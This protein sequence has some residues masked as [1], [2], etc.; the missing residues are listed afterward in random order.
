MKV[1][2]RLSVEPGD[3]R[4]S[5]LPDKRKYRHICQAYLVTGQKGRDS[6]TAVKILENHHAFC[7]MGLAIHILI[8]A[9]IFI[10]IQMV[11]E[12]TVIAFDQGITVA[13]EKVIVRQPPQWITLRQYLQHDVQALV[14]HR[15]IWQDENGHC[16]LRA[17]F[18]HFCGFIAQQDLAPDER[19]TTRDQRQPR[20]HGIGATSE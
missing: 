3:I 5:K 13:A 7:S 16:P 1:W 19:H 9:R 11:L 4:N 2:Q 18:Q 10:A 8:P 20:T 12:W 15:T 17:L 6:Q 14:N